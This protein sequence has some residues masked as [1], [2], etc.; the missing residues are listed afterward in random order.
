MITIKE[1]PPK[2]FFEGF[3]GPY[4]HGEQMTFGY[5][6]LKAGCKV[7]L[8]AHVHEQI[9]YLIE[10]NL[11]MMVDGKEYSLHAGNCLI[12]PSSAV[13]SAYAKK[14]S[15]IIDVFNPVREEYR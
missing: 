10:G 5:V 4:V 9:T 13:H 15:K 11:E 7:P 8:H 6:E 14:D 1:I 3:K 12:I 2:T